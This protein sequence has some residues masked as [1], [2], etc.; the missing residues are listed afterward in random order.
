MTDRL[1]GK[2]AFVSGAGS[3]P[4][5]VS[6]GMACSVKYAREGARIFAVDR[7]ETALE[8]TL[9]AIAEEGGEAQ[10]YV[11]DMTNPVEVEAAV[12][13]CLERFGTIDIL[14]N[15]IGAGTPGGPVE[16]SEEDWDRIIATNITSAFLACKHVLPVM[17][18]KGAGVIVNISSV[19]SKIYGGQSYIN[20]AASKAA[21]DQFTQAVALENAAKGIRCN[22]ILPGLIATPF[23]FSVPSMAAKAAG[24][25]G[26]DKVIPSDLV[27]L[28]HLGSPWDVADAAVFLASDDAAFITGAELLVDGGFTSTVSTTYATGAAR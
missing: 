23:A 20:Y 6:N 3:A 12:A 8:K 26:M 1:P 17:L 28:G 4:E 19:A 27:P 5:G 25:G 10:G 14:H 2:V 15:N 22:A 9:N 16:T 24:D 11:A 13:A 21:L 18:E 7:H